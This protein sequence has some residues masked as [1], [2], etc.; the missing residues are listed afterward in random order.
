MKRLLAFIFVILSYN[1]LP[2]QIKRQVYGL[3]VGINE[4]QP[5]VYPL[6]NSVN[7]AT[8]IYNIFG[9]GNK[10]TLLTDK[11][12][13]RQAI[14]K[15]VSNTLEKAVENDLVVFYF[16]GMGSIVEKELFFL[17]SDGEHGN[18]NVIKTGVSARV[19]NN[20]ISSVV[21]RGVKVLL[22]LDFAFA[23]AWGF[24]LGKYSSGEYSKGGITLLFSAGPGEAALDGWKGA[25]NSP[26]VMY[27]TEGL[28]GPADASNDGIVTIR[29]MFNYVYLKFVDPK[30]DR[31]S[32]MQHPIMIGTLSNDY[33]VKI[34]P[35]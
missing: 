13:T 35:R 16:A 15:A 5:P 31:H 18:A 7:D 27:L 32:D 11:D 2:A 9:R 20:A 30:D 28:Q 19:I 14:L 1:P 25:K 22:I 3:F 12:A 26:F 23:G 6:V 21:K 33:P 24:D 34:F 4:Y 17:G 8:T 29:E 10:S